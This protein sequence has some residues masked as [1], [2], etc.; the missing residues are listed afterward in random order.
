MVSMQRID[1]K[2]TSGSCTGVKS[3]A[4]LLMTRCLTFFASGQSCDHFFELAVPS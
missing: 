1:T 3:S 2:G 4:N